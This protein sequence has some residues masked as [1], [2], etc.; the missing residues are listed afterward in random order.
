V[1]FTV[2]MIEIIVSYKIEKI[3]ISNGVKSTIWTLGV[4]SIDPQHFLTGYNC[5]SSL[6]A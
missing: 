6:F 4:E 3:Q 2:F 1:P 5:L